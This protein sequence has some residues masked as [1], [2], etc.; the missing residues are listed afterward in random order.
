MYKKLR[1]TEGK[2]NEDRV[3]AIKKML[4][5]M[6][7]NMLMQEQFNKLFLLVK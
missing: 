4:D 5:K 7:E 2:K 3:E 1:D 6:K